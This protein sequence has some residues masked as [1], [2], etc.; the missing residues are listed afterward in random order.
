MENSGVHFCKQCYNMTFIHEQID[1]D[2]KKLIHHCKTCGENE[3]FNTENNCIYSLSFEKFDVSQ[4]INENKYITHDKT[5]PNITDNVNIK[6]CNEECSTNTNSEKT[7]FKFIKYDD[8][9][10]KYVYICEVCGQKWS[11]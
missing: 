2:K 11:N 6:C 9:D 10:M 7:S 4:I 3:D 5:L 8:N 1:G